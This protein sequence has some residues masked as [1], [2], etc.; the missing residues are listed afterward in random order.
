MPNDQPKADKKISVT[1][2][3]K[4]DINQ[5]GQAQKVFGSHL[6]RENEPAT[7]MTNNLVNTNNVEEPTHFE[8]SPVSND[9]KRQA[10]DQK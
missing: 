4:T 2:G 5:T 6:T 7:S 9:Q 1:S 10:E 3:G 8:Q